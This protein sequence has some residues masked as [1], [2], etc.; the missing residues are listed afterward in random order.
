MKYHSKF[1]MFVF[2]MCRI[3][4]FRALH[5]STTHISTKNARILAFDF[6]GV[7]C[8]SAKES[9]STAT[10]TAQEIWPNIQNKQSWDEVARK[11]TIV[12]PVIE[13]GYEIV[14]LARTFAEEDE[15][16][17]D[18]SLEDLL[19]SWSP[20]R[21]D[22]LI[23]KY[24]SSRVRINQLH[25]LSIMIKFDYIRKLSSTHSVQLVID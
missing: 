12:R 23:S 25:R 22:L 20:S 9:S 21:R 19:D 5:K 15:Y 24:S 4:M 16:L 3:G 13:T 1:I 8:A 18:D 11:L 2:I 14:L 10:V 17:N 6:D 7:F